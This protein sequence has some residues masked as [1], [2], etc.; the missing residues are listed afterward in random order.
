LRCSADYLLGLQEDG[1]NEPDSP[2]SLKTVA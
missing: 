1:E 2:T